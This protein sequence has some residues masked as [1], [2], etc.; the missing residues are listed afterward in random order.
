MLWSAVR[1]IPLPRSTLKQNGGIFPVKKK[2]ANLTDILSQKGI[3]MLLPSPAELEAM[4]GPQRDS[5]ATAV[6]PYRTSQDKEHFP[7]SI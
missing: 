5:E 6:T 2:K 1:P 7:G 3:T 4:L